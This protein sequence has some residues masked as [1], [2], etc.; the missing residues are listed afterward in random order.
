MS[1]PDPP[2]FH[3]RMPPDLKARLEAVRGSRSLNREIVERLE[4]S[5][6]TDVASEFGA[7]LAA[8][9]APLKDEDRAKALRLA[10]ELATI[11]APKPRRRRTP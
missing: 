5:L 3:L 9:L 1:R 4:R 10:S 11:L 7:I 2:S 6:S 8:Y